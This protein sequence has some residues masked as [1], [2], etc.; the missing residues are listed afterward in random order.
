MP[1]HRARTSLLTSLA[2]Q[3]RVIWALFLREVLTRFGRDNIGFLW[4]FI[5]PML[6]TVAVT[7]LWG[8]IGGT[9]GG[10][11]I[12]GFALTGYGVLVF[13]R[14]TFVRL[15]S[16]ASSNKSLLYHRNVRVIDM[17][18]SR[19][20][21]EFASSTSAL[22]LLT[23]FFTSMGLMDLPVDPLKAVIAWL[24]AA[25]FIIGLGMITSYIGEVSE[26]FHRVAGIFTF[27]TLV[28]TGAFTMVRWLPKPAQVV[29]LWSPLVNCVEMLRE[30]YF[31]MGIGA[32]Y[33]IEYVV[34]VNSLT[35]LVGLI[36]IRKIRSALVDD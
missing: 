25:W 30:G 23:F 22:V 16:S 36:L 11:P 18:L 17:V 2:I 26:L 19:G 32:I 13:Y 35:M 1:D 33:S 3:R 31:G 6:F 21:L 28:F 20:L 5:E 9:R 15:A 27:M 24:L 12:A 29:L 10:L 7:I 34:L 4:L 14:S 8:V